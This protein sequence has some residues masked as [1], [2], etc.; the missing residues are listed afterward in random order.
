[1][2]AALSTAVGAVIVAVVGA[3]VGLRNGTKANQPAES[4]AQLAWV[5]Q[6]QEE[7]KEART[8][9]KEA[10]T[11]VDAVRRENSQIIREHQQ[12]RGEFAAMRDWVDG[13]VRAR[14]A[15]M[16]THPIEELDDTGQIRLLRAINGGPRMPSDPDHS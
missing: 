4:N 15:Y 14:N 9:A 1:M 5:K 7:A 2:D 3:V 10:R 12:M 11:E 13:V 6:A 16:E 8:E